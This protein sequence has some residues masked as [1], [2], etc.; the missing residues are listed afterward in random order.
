M[1][2]LGR[3]W[4]GGGRYQA[5]DLVNP[6][7]THNVCPPHGG[8]G[9]AT[10]TGPDATHPPTMFQNLEGGGPAGG[11]GGAGGGLVPAGGWGGV[12]PGVRGWGVGV[13]VKVT[14]LV[15]PVLVL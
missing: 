4:G 7:N 9:G 2:R 10:T 1:S 14:E 13:R 15:E 6:L 3:G 8:G 5:L 12:Q 11:R